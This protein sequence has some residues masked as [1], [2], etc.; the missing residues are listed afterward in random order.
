MIVGEVG[1]FAPVTT[2][3]RTF[4]G[5]GADSPAKQR[6][7]R[8]WTH[9]VAPAW[10]THHNRMDANEHHVE[11]SFSPPR[12]WRPWWSRLPGTAGAD[13]TPAPSPFQIIGPNGPVVQGIPHISRRY[14]WW[15]RWPARS[16]TPLVGDEA[17][18]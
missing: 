15:P 8:V 5:P 16:G 17:K 6:H 7:R 11:T 12:L 10:H 9:V 3:R 2:V 13:P 18:T 1:A 14:A 4:C